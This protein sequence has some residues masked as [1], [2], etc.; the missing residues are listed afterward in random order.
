MKQQERWSSQSLG[1]AQ[2]QGAP[3]QI[4][5]PAAAPPMHP[6]AP[7][8]STWPRPRAGPGT[9]PLPA[10][11]PCPPPPRPSRKPSRPGPMPCGRSRAASPSRPP[12]VRP[13]LLLSPIDI[14]D[15]RCRM[16]YLYCTQHCWGPAGLTSKCRT[17]QSDAS[18]SKLW[19]RHHETSTDH[20]GPCKAHAGTTGCSSGRPSIL[21]QQ[22][23]CSEDQHDM[24]SIVW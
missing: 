3:P 7:A 20:H 4:M 16:A 24:R 12:Q 11:P 1:Q 19:L 17:W 18:L 15:F 10:T 8:T 9:C 21:D 6:A 14:A 13:V 22:W 5:R 23:L 2:T